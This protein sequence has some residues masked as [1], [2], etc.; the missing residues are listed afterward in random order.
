MSLFPFCEHLPATLRVGRRARWRR[1]G[2]HPRRLFRPGLERLE[3]RCIPSVDLTD[4]GIWEARGPGP[5]SD[6]SIT[7]VVNV[8]GSRLDNPFV[9]AVEALAPHPTNKNILYAGTTNGGVWKTTDAYDRDPTWIPL[10]DQF[11]SLSISA[12]A[13]SPMD[14]THNT[15]FAGI[16][17][18]SNFQTASGPLSS[19]AILRTTDGGLTWT[20]LGGSTFSGLTIASIVPTKLGTNA[21]HQVILVAAYD[22]GFTPSNASARSGIYRSTD[23]GATF[24]L[25]PTSSVDPGFPGGTATAISADPTNPNLF[26]AGIGQVKPGGSQGQGVLRSTDGGQH[27]SPFNTGLT[28]F[29]DAVRIRLAVVNHPTSAGVNAVFAA[30]VGPNGKLA[31]LYQS[32][33]RGVH[34]VSMGDSGLGDSTPPDLN[35]GQNGGINLSIAVNPNNPNFV[36]VG[37]DVRAVVPIPAI[38]VFGAAG[39][40]PITGLFDRPHP[41]SRDMVFDAAGQLLEADDGGVYRFV[42]NDHWDAVTGSLSNTEITSVAYDALNDKLFAGAQ[43][44]GLSEEGRGFSG[45]Q[46]WNT[47]KGGDGQSV[48][49][50]YITGA[51]GQPESIRYAMGNNLVASFVGGLHVRV[52][53]AGN[54]QVTD[55]SAD[56]NGLDSV[57][58]DSA[59]GS[60]AHHFPLAVDLFDGNRIVFGGHSLYESTDRGNTLNAVLVGH[61]GDLFNTGAVVYGGTLRIAGIPPVIVHDPGVIVAAV[62]NMTL[63]GD[64]N[65][66]SDA[67]FH[68]F[69]RSGANQPMQK[70]AKDPELNGAPISMVVDPDDWRKVYI[71]DGTQIFYN[72][73]ITDAGSDWISIPIPVN[74]NS[75]QI[76]TIHCLEVASPTIL[77]GDEVL[78]VGAD[79]GVFKTENPHDAS[80]V[81]TEV[82]S[83][84]PNAPVFDLHYIPAGASKAAIPTDDVLV[85]GTL[86]RGAWIL[87]GALSTLTQPAS[88][89]TINGN[90]I[91]G[92]NHFTLNTTILGADLQGVG[93]FPRPVLNVFD[94]SIRP[95]QPP[96]VP[97]AQVPRAAID[98]I[99]VNG[100]SENDTLAID[101]PNGV[102]LLPAGGLAFQGGGGKN[103]LALTG[104]PGPATYTPS[105]NN[106]DD[107]GSGTLDFT[108]S[109]QSI[110]FSNMAVVTG[111]APTIT[112]V[113]LDKTTVDRGEAV[114]VNGAFVAP[115]T[116]GLFTV[117]INWAGISFGTTPPAGS[118]SLTVL[119]AG[120]RTFHVVHPAVGTGDRE[121]I[122]RV[123]AGDGLSDQRLLP[124]TV[125]GN[126]IKATSVKST[127]VQGATDTVL[128]AH[129]VDPVGPDAIPA[130]FDPKT[131]PRFN[132]TATINWG[133]DTNPTLG[134]ISLDVPQSAS[135]LT[136][137]KPPVTPIVFDVLGSHAY[138]ATGTFTVT[139][140]IHHAGADTTVVSTITVLAIANHPNARTGPLVIGASTAGDTIKVMSVGGSTVL[141]EVFVNGSSQG[142]FSGFTNIEI[143]GQGG[144]DD[145]EVDSRIQKNALLVGRGGNDTLRGGG[146]NDTLL[147]GDG[148][149]VLDGG[150]GKNTLDGGAGQDGVV[151]RGTDGDDQIGVDWQLGPNG[152]QVVAHINGRTFVEDYQNG[153]TVFVF[154]GKG[155]DV[156]QILPSAAGHWRAELHGEEGN[157]ILLGGTH[158]D[159]LDGGDGN[160]VLVGGG[161]GSEL[162]GGGGRNVLIAGPEASTLVGG[163]DD[164]LL[165]AG[166]TAFDHNTR[167]LSA[168]VAEWSSARSYAD[169]VANLRGVGMGPRA[170]GNYFLTN[171]R[172]HATTMGADD[173]VLTGSA[174][175]DWFFALLDEDSDD[176]VTDLAANEFL[177]ALPPPLGSD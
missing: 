162:D 99:E 173:I 141:V 170:N 106:P 75:L 42:D 51:D 103:T 47:W 32:V 101:F 120:V 132:Y 73:N 119:R 94:D 81:W 30:L 136:A 44:S 76:G 48:G 55:Q 65:P 130:P 158:D 38:D 131:P 140:T 54:Q 11:P 34:W 64:P 37:G 127:S 21:A 41:D 134:G 89:L 29:K 80:P 46:V 83:G 146:G 92:D 23:G 77:P 96:A 174:G 145:L 139:V 105:A 126:P 53:G 40:Q 165:V 159:L 79:G 88:V 25:L 144:D 20:Q 1:S 98:K 67:N 5:I 154:A 31:G 69:F 150:A 137:T 121:I 13:F 17:A 14:S 147:G 86:G 50:G 109:P 97:T 169:R 164:D 4:L 135:A 176:Q 70:V 36:Y 124:I 85:A 62:A 49:I 24:Q 111:V 26:Y 58:G 107:V 156:V 117:V 18:M 118:T 100:G 172:A 167:A 16:G 123:I 115:G 90:P 66:P 68:V 171:T 133:D 157:D 148:N 8:G 71:T 177:D 57:D 113:Q 33:D 87:R 7:P 82:G 125:V 45:M 9:G 152:A 10:T 163:S 27:W 155:N 72:P 151:I 114:T 149:D 35:A 74:R 93:A 19:P 160:D 12:L 102:D 128:V 138:V 175:R 22:P 108:F 60:S 168:I 6:G 129:F 104:T 61:G 43:D 2:R 84:L 153:E 56:L 78:L 28:G 52:Y 110:Q 142:R 15:L 161:N 39:S 166:T 91:V 59:Q 95:A 143:Y 122:V 112:D 63:P 116:A 3:G